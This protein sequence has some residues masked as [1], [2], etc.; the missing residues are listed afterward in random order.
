MAHG[1]KRKVTAE[2]LYQIRQVNDPQASPDGRRVVYTVTQAEDKGNRYVAA[3]W[4][5]DLASGECYRLTSGKHRDGQPRW[6][7]DGMTIAFTSD[8]NDDDKGKGQ[9]WTISVT[10]GEPVR[11]SSLAEPV[12]EFAWS[13]DGRAIAAV[14]K[15]LIGPPRPASG[16]RVVTTP[17]YRFDGEGYLDDKYRQVFVIDVESGSARQLTDGAYEHQGVSWSPSGHELA[18]ASNRND[19]WEYSNVRDIYAIRV[20]GKQIR[21]VT[22]G[23]GAWSRPSW[24][25]DGTQI[26]MYG[27]RRLKSDSPRTEVFVV[28]ASGGAPQS[29]TADFDRS[30]TDGCIADVISYPVRPP[31]WEPDGSAVN[32]VFSDAG[33]VQM[34]RVPLA[35]G[36][37]LPLTSGRRRVGAI[38]RLP[39]GGFVYAANTATTPGELFVCVANGT[40]ERRLTGHNDAWLEDVALSEP[41]PF[42]V[43]SADGTPVHGWI[44]QPVGI[45]TGNLYPLA[46]EIHGGPFGMYG[47]TMMHEFQLLAARGYGVLYTNPRG[48]TGYGDEFAGQLFRAWGIN[49]FPDQMAAVDWAIAQGWVNGERLAVLGGSYGGFMT[50]WVISHT[51][52]FKA[53]VTG[54]T[55]SNMYSM[56]GTD[57]IFHASAEQTVGALPWEDPEIY[58]EL[59]PLTY[60]ANIETPLLIEQQEEDYRCPM[61]Q[62]EQLYIALKRLGKT[63]E[64]VRFPDESHGM[65]RT[66]QPKHR[67]ERLEHILRWFDM[68]V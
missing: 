65:S 24:S 8:R 68:H 1:E 19:G 59:S 56:F 21:K 66:G 3:L 61:E 23:T 34:A 33:T 20:Q 49:D 11:L 53:A 48:S 62:A 36:D 7:P 29:L 22:D 17:R 37:V 63:V 67:I 58:F 41:Q 5:V 26:A 14:S 54:R 57:D 10:G 25:P 9:I 55:I 16:V 6:S 52:R 31:L 46:L 13:P 12:E 40:E 47:E 4:L 42:V 15:V 43:S 60:V 18:C 35:G 32:V 51:T 44:M 50:N 27:T 39:D 38:D 45:T 28:A 64:F 2:D 30:C